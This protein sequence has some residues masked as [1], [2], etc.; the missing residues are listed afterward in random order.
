VIFGLM[1]LAHL[2]RIILRMGLQVGSW[3]IGRRWSVA[4]ALVL[5]ALCGW[6]WTLA[7][8]A[9]K[10]KAETPPAKPAA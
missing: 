5:A 2:I 7:S 10:P 1:G 8:Q 4:I 3:F 9:A 6:L